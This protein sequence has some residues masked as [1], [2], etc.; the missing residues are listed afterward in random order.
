LKIKVL[1]EDFIVK[2]KINLKLKNKGKYKIY[3]LI[4]KHWNTTD[5]IKFIAKESNI[6]INLIGTGG[7][8][9]R[10]AVTYQYISCPSQYSLKFSASENVKLDFIGFADDYVSPLL[11][12]GND[13][14][15]TL[16]KIS[17]NEK[18][19]ILTRLNQITE[20]GYANYFDDQRFGSVENSAEFI[21][22]KIVKGH[23]N[24]ALKLYF[25]IIHPEDKKEEK[26]RKRKINELWGDFNQVLKYCK[27]TT[28]K[29]IIR[30]I[31]VK[32]SKSN[33]A[34][35]INLIPKDELSMYFS[36]YQSFLW[37][38]TLTYILQE[39]VDS[40]FLVKGKIMDY[41]LYKTLSLNSYKR[42]R[43]LEIPTISYKTPK[44]DKKVDGII[45]EI[46]SQREVKEGDFNLR[47][48]RKAFYKS[49][50]RKAIVFPENLSYSEFVEDD[51]YKGYYKVTL[52]F[53]LPTGSFATMLIKSLTI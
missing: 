33:L 21:G 1:P 48:V 8:K 19:N 10:H 12:E 46:L 38:L 2:E 37:N 5:A 6:P 53:G 17:E 36:A 22:E 24:G 14:E 35:A 42:L 28:Q 4:K 43:D 45:R 9:D 3:L 20:F 47:D 25:T 32:K 16:R 15:I 11:L 40:L 41:Y 26:E 51:F 18:D 31:M 13:F 23:Y 34:K 29:A 44:V 39:E 7:R 50:L 27:T 49:F 30:Q 52:S